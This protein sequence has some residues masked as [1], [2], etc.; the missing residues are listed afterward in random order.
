[1]IARLLLAASAMAVLSG[2]ATTPLPTW[3]ALDRLDR[4]T[5][6][7]SCRVTLVTAIQTDA[8]RP[9]LRYYPFVERRGSEIR[10][11]VMANPRLPLPVGAVQVRINDNTAWTIDASETPLDT[12]GT[13]PLP[14]DAYIPADATPAQVEAI[15]R[16]A[17]AMSSTVNQAMSPYTAVTGAKADQILAQMKTGSRVIYRTL[18]ANSS[19]TTGE[20]VLGPQFN[21]A[22]T[23]CGI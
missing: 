6:Q 20:A 2:C 10:V 18:G 13:A 21:Q 15:R 5:D 1:M 12:Q 16:S 3:G 23:R 4:F 22:L 11:G 9:H 17:E 7:S 19:S 8:Y 14:L